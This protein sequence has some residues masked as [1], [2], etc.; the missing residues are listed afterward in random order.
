MRWTAQLVRST[1]ARVE[2]IEKHSK[3]DEMRGGSRW[4]LVW[5]K[6]YMYLL[7]F[8]SLNLE[9]MDSILGTY[10]KSFRETMID[11]VTIYDTAEL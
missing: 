3:N 2:V 1:L 10:Q 7:S 11:M 8:P 5:F 6:F 9:I 4:N